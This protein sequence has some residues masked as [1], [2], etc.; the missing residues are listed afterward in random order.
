MKPTIDYSELR[1][2][3]ESLKWAEK[4]N[5]PYEE[6]EHYRKYVLGEEIEYPPEQKRRMDLGTIV[7][8]YVENPTYE[9]VQKMTEAGFNNALI[10]KVQKLYPRIQNSGEHQKVMFVDMG[11]G[12]KLKTKL[13]R[14]LKDERIID[15]YKTT[16]QEF[17]WSQRKVDE[18]KQLSTY[19]FA[20]LENYH[21]P[22]RELAIAEINL[23]KNGR[24][25]RWLTQ[26]GPKDME[27]IKSWIWGLVDDMKRRGIWE[28][29]KSWQ[30]IEF[31]R[32]QKVGNTLRI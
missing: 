7:G 25:K 17:I 5:K 9:F 14:F 19:A 10:L 22:L 26:R 18:D 4:E 21:K 23:A 3:E 20:F 1:N 28:K 2:Y 15:D 11:Q 12:V 8:N 32:N 16:E 30:E 13:D 31:L 29:R 24:F 27:F 6:S